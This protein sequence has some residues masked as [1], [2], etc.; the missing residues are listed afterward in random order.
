MGYV[1]EIN[2]VEMLITPKME[3]KR[4]NIDETAY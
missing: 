4:S 3:R 1:V 2:G